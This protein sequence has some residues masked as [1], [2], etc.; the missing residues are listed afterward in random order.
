[1]AQKLEQLVQQ[2][3]SLPMIPSVIVKVNE[4]ASNP[5]TSAL[6]LARTIMGDQALTARLLRVVNSPFYGFPRNIST[7][8]EAV[9]IL[10]FSPVRNLLLSSSV[11]DLLA[12][13]E[14]PDFS[15]IAHWEHSVGTAVAASR[16]ARY[17]DYEDPEEVFISALLHDVGKLVLFH[18]APNEYIMVRKTARA[19]DIP[20]RTAEQR[21][22][23]YAHDQ[24]GRLLA[25][26]WKLPVRLSDAVGSHHRPDLAEESK[27]AAVIV[28]AADVIAHAMC[29]GVEDD[30][31]PPLHQECW[32]AL[33]FPATAL[34]TMAR[35]IEERFQD[36]RSV[37]LSGLQSRA[38][39]THF[40]Q[41]RVTSRN[42][43]D[44]F[45]GVVSSRSAERRKCSA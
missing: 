7:V 19:E 4:Q 21:T 22:L 32:A 6:D 25:E 37:L 40:Q 8:T 12:A 17:V 31:V 38:G 11:V 27:R 41:F 39:Q 9:T 28:H 10:G 5:Q 36:A 24:V 2:L 43:P 29:F 13:D 26:R 3:D 42:A 16:I 14:T 20:V 34:D 33:R 23:G 1:M 35:E 18:C 45:H 44:S 15:P 30:A